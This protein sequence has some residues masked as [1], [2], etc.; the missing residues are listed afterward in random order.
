[1]MLREPVV[2]SKVMYKAAV[3]YFGAL[4]IKYCKGAHSLCLSA[5]SDSRADFLEI[6]P[7]EILLIISV[8][9]GFA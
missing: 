2:R 1:M 3:L 9:F 6:L 5:R 8:H 7:W 4:A